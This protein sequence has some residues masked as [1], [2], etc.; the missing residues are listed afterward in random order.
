MIV[1]ENLFYLLL[2]IVVVFI[3]GYIAKV[4]FLY[5]KNVISVHNEQTFFKKFK[6]KKEILNIVPNTRLKQLLLGAFIL[7]NIFLYLEQ[8]TQWISSKTE[9]HEAKEY[10]VSN[11]TLFF[12]RKLLNNIFVID[13]VFMK[14]LNMLNDHIYSRGIQYL[15]KDDG[16]IG[17]W[18]Y[19]FN[20]YF[21]TRGKG[22]LP[23][24]S[25][26]NIK[27][28][29]L[30]EHKKILDDIYNAIDS[31]A[32][33]PIKDKQVFPEK[34]KVSTLMGDYFINNRFWYFS[35]DRGYYARLIS[36]ENEDFIQKMENLL[37]WTLEL[38]KE[39]KQDNALKKFIEIKHPIIGF[40]YIDIVIELSKSLIHGKYINKEFDCDDNMIDLFLEY[41]EKLVEQES[42]LYR[43]S[44]SQQDIIVNYT[45]DGT[46]EQS[47]VY[48][49]DKQCGKKA[50]VYYPTQEWIDKKFNMGDKK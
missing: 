12:Y 18:Q 21:Y 27:T 35:N 23:N 25:L 30:Q 7:F 32:T 41:R 9:H 19:R 37:S 29:P 2:I 3:Y 40:T 36:Y 8:R 20:S 31:L 13:S 28:P 6:P 43:L 10:Y 4:I 14:P 17:F 42:P 26:S 22:Y 34:Y 47:L 48:Y 44:K 11:A 49:I 46:I 15:P 38:E 45:F 24:Q 16:E 33:K 39:Y 1:I 50:T 5:I